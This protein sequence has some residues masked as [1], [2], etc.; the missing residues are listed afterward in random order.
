M[1][2]F[3]IECNSVPVTL[4]AGWYHM[5]ACPPG[6]RWVSSRSWR[7]RTPLQISSVTA[8]PLP[9]LQ[10]ST[11]T[12]CSTGSYLRI[13]SE[14]DGFHQNK[15]PTHPVFIY[16]GKTS[17]YTLAPPLE[18]F[19]GRCSKMRVEWAQMGVPS[20]QWWADFQMRQRSFKITKSVSQTP[21]A[22]TE[23]PAESTRG[24]CDFK[25]ENHSY[26]TSLSCFVVTR[27]KL[28]KAIEEFTLSCAG[29]C[30]AT[31]VLGI[32]DRHNDNIMIRETGQVLWYL[33][34][35]GFSVWRRLFI[36]LYYSPPT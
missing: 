17:A 12:L 9:P 24:I 27:G 10:P 25:I 35:I 14:C 19:L 28:E 20:S 5:D 4:H 8:A 11:R 34:V 18:Q 7:T 3:W 15:P 30:V 33:T 22:T 36:I 23:I 29:Y 31:Y 6:T 1:I 21:N 26:L 13:R 32:R 2:F 16:I